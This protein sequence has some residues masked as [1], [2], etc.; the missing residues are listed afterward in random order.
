MV[1]VESGR[2]KLPKRRNTGRKKIG[3][4]YH[5]KSQEDFLV[6]KIISNEYSP[7]WPIAQFRH[8]FFFI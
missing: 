2:C 3:V 8:I 5:E 7:T 6:R 4:K 1:D